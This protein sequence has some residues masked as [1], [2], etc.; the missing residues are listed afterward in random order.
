MMC[1]GISTMV[2]QIC[3]HVTQ[4]KNTFK[5]KIATIK[6]NLNYK[7]RKEW[8]THPLLNLV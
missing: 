5:L 3:L 2:L 1:S 8:K 7:L 4:K 6:M